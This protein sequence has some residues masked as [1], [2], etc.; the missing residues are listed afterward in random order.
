M[1]KGKFKVWRNGELIGEYATREE[2]E[3]RKRESEKFDALE[4]MRWGYMPGR[5]HITPR[6]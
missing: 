4:S 5:H 1:A 2:A 6:K 3:T